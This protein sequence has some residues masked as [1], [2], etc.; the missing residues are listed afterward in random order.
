MHSHRR[1]TARKETDRYASHSYA[2]HE[3]QSAVEC[4]PLHSVLATTPRLWLTLSGPLSSSAVLVNG[5][6]YHRW[7]CQTCIGSIWGTVSPQAILPSHLCEQQTPS[8]EK[9]A[10]SISIDHPFKR[11][12]RIGHRLVEQ[13]MIDVLDVTNARERA[14]EALRY[15]R[16]AYPDASA[17]DLRTLAAGILH[18][19]AQH[20][21]WR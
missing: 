20:K 5:R 13:G 2:H 19:W 1:I 11:G 15:A 6:L 16:Y 14:S 10:P 3:P 12:Q 7:L 17:E 18:Q 21:Q 4:G 8:G 9:E